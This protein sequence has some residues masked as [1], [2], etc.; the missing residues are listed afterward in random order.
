MND[1]EA[2]IF[3]R[4]LRAM[5]RDGQIMRNRKGAICLMEKL[6]LI[7][8]KV[9]GH[10]DGFGFLVPEDGSPDLFLSGKQMDK[11]LH[12]DRVMARQIG[13]DRRGR[14]E[15]SIVEVLEH[16]NTQRWL[17]VSTSSTASCS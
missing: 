13:V 2:D 5:E 10:A 15:G 7:K 3:S 11:V 1:E 17:G 9:Q 4:R 6:D 8:G 16:V 12:G 14:P